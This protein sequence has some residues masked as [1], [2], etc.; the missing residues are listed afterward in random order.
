MLCYTALLLLAVAAA[1]VPQFPRQFKAEVAMT[2][3][4]VDKVRP[5]RP[6]STP[7]PCGSRFLLFLSCRGVSSQ[8]L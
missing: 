6:S 4:Q 2:A 5:R 7:V 8:A 3:H 1:G